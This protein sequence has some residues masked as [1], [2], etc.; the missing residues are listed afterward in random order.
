MRK[1]I[2]ENKKCKLEQSDGFI[3]TGIVLETDTYGVIFKTD[4]KTSFIHWNNIRK[5]Y[6]CEEE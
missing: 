1:E 6:P 4:Q 5:L 2:L 3:L